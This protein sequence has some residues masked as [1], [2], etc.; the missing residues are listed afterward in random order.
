[1]RIISFIFLLIISTHSLSEMVLYSVASVKAIKGTGFVKLIGSSKAEINSKSV[2]FDKSVFI[3][4][5][6]ISSLTSV[7][8][9]G[10]V[11]PISVGGD[12]NKSK[13]IEGCV[14]AYSSGSYSERISVM[15]QGCI[16]IINEIKSS[17]RL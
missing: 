7:F 6:N 1:M 14:I 15:E 9:G 4:A 10:L 8:S 16:N 17:I 5:N 12:G 3:Q 2:D 13:K 11:I